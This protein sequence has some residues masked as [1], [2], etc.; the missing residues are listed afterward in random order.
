MFTIFNNIIFAL[1][2]FINIKLCLTDVRD[3]CEGGEYSTLTMNC[4]SNKL[5]RN[6]G[7]QQ[8]R[9]DGLN[10]WNTNLTAELSE[11]DF[12]GN[13][14]NQPQRLAG[15]NGNYDYIINDIAIYQRITNCNNEYLILCQQLINSCILRLWQDVSNAYCS[16]LLDKA[17]TRNNLIQLLSQDK[18][19]DD[20]I[21]ISYTLDSDNRN[22]N[23]RLN[24][25]VGKFGLNGTFLKFERL[26]YDFLP[27][28][29]S[30]EGK[31]NHRIFIFISSFHFVTRTYIFFW[32]IICNEF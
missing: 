27:C 26:E 20:G 28:S 2:V 32:K 4:K 17:N 15:G 7:C 1:F 13:Y 12:Y 24:F 9:E 23:R 14:F 5:T 18:P 10:C 31:T 30:Q 22:D 6:L 25:W 11:K 29:N 19:S 21:G 3:H 8:Y 16:L